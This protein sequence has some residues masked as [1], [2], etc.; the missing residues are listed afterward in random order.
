MASALNYEYDFILYR[1][2]LV[3][4]A[5][6][7]DILR[8]AS[9]VS[10]YRKTRLFLVEC[11]EEFSN[12]AKNY[13]AT[14]DLEIL[15][16]QSLQEIKYI[17]L[18]NGIANQII[19]THT[20]PTT[21]FSAVP[22]FRYTNLVLIEDLLPLSDRLPS[23][24]K[25]QRYIDRILTKKVSIRMIT[26][27]YRRAIHFAKVYFAISDSQEYVMKKYYGLQSDDVVY[28]PVDDRFFH[29]S[30][31][32]RTSL[33]V[34]GTPDKDVIRCVFNSVGSGKIKEIIIVNSDLSPA[35]VS[36]S[37]VKI[38][39]IRNYTFQEISDIYRRTLLS[40]TCESRGSFELT[41][42]ES[43]ISGVPIISPAVPSLKVL[44]NRLDSSG[45]QKEQKVY[46]FF[47]YI[48]LIGKC[49]K[50]KISKELVDWYFEVENQREF[51]STLCNKIF[52]IDEIGRDFIVKVE[53]HLFQL[54]EK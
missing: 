35:D 54:S 19:V 51:F 36:V 2:T 18:K 21:L 45:L 14:Y 16:V 47:D 5:I 38:T 43:I 31:S 24:I 34:F 32:E 27:R 28:A 20:W 40:I 6:S 52:S 1:E 49:K 11:L 33:M 46:P 9:G 37:D 41:P 50:K 8:R 29:Y 48:N 10:K 15:L 12:Y 42:I 23:G 53:Q 22:V 17:I 26:F 3:F 4:G 39:K 13:T 30:E 7:S 25:N 44:T